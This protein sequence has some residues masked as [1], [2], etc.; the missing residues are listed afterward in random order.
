MRV[1]LDV[2]GEFF[3]LLVHSSLRGPRVGIS[4]HLHSHSHSHLHTRV[5][6]TRV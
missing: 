2:R 6:E 3:S 1:A 4:V 5:C